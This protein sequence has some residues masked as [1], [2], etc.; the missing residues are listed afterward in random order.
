MG[1]EST[2]PAA[3]RPVDGDAGSSSVCVDK[4]KL[5]HLVNTKYMLFDEG[6]RNT[7]A[8][9]RGRS[10]TTGIHVFYMESALYNGHGISA[11]TVVDKL[12]WNKKIIE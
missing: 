11:F 8:S 3:S 9:F 5:F 12:N 10:R 2:F 6:R 7:R 4:E 1:V